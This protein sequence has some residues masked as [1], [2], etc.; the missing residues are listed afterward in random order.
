MFFPIERPRPPPNTRES[1]ARRTHYFAPVI[2]NGK[3]RAGK[4]SVSESGAKVTSPSISI[5]GRLPDPAIVTCNE[6]LP[7]R[8]LVTKQN[9]SPA[10][11]FLQVLHIQ[12]VGQTHIRALELRR[13]EVNEWTVLSRADMKMPLTKQ[14]RE[15]DAIV[16]EIDSSLWK[17]NPLPNSVAPTFETCNISR[18]YFL[19]I[20]VGLSWGTGT[21][22]NVRFQ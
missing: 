20:K 11:I 4:R 7:L 8:L 16:F 14:N 13:D 17:Q 18:S 3:G 19:D 21:A 1:F 2:E 9:D 10:T 12:L 5:D 15:T 22:I 6:S